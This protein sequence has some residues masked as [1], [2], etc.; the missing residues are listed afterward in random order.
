MESDRFAR[1]QKSTGMHLAMEVKECLRRISDFPENPKAMDYFYDLFNKTYSGDHAPQ[2]DQPLIGTMCV[3]VPEELIIAA[4]ARPLRLCSGA[5]AYDQ[6]GADFMPAK[7]CPLIKATA[8]M[9]HV[10]QD[11][12]GDA[13]KSVVIPTTCDQKKKSAELLQSMGYRVNILEMPASK[14]SDAARFYWQESIKQFSLDLQK[15]TGKKITTAGLKDA[16]AKT[17]R[18]ASLFRK[19]YELRKADPATIFGKDIFLVN[20]A[21]FFD[22]LERW[23]QAVTLLIAELEERQSN[24]FRISNRQAPRILFTGSPPIFPNLKVPLL[25]EEAGAIVV[26]DE[27]CSSNRM[28]YDAVSY[29]EENLNDMVPALADRYLKP[30][31]CPCLS[32]NTDRTRKLADMSDSYGV[33]GI[34]YQS[35]SGCIPYEMEQR[36]VNEAM[37]KHNVPV[38]YLETDYSPEDVGQLSTRIE[39]FIESIKARRRKKR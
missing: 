39:A 14:D 15:I 38:L 9:L 10:N 28:L 11:F 21:Y 16:I 34:V 37:S 17:S 6:V 27:V 26:A 35:F 4:G 12:W 19:L 18:A 13:L 3:Q 29:D 23:Q 33:D 24:N 1:M 32:N 22:D 25:V 30:C 5:Y 8:G 2:T 36:Q 20:N 7:S 31:T